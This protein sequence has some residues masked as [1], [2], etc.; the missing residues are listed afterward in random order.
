LK[1]IT[2][3]ENPGKTPY[4][5]AKDSQMKC[6]QISLALNGSQTADAKNLAQRY[7]EATNKK[8]EREKAEKEKQEKVAAKEAAKQAI[9]EKIREAKR[10]KDMEADG[11]QKNGDSPKKGDCETAD[12]EGV[13]QMDVEQ[14]EKS[15]PNDDS[16]LTASTTDKTNAGDSS[17]ENPASDTQSKDSTS[18]N[19]SDSEASQTGDKQCTSQTDKLKSSPLLES[20]NSN[21]LLA[22]VVEEAADDSR[23]PNK[24][25]QDTEFLPNEEDPYQSWSTGEVTMA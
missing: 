22:S 24:S 16:I 15:N 17:D 25:K 1:N 19:D 12:C 8:K 5:Y 11:E 3:I 2:P 18:G 21:P 9:K 23:S 13:A 4:Y 14:H 10:K 20:D 6:T 7:S